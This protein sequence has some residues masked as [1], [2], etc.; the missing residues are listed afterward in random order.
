MPATHE[1]SGTIRQ[2]AWAYELLVIWPAALISPLRLFLWKS[3]S[4]ASGHEHPDTGAPLM[5]LPGLKPTH[6]LLSGPVGMG[7]CWSSR[8]GSVLHL[9]I[10]C[11]DCRKWLGVKTPASLSVEMD[12]GI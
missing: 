11:M 6:I 3:V 5:W 12:A 8:L 2:E 9:S 7:A 10:S 1:V 4:V